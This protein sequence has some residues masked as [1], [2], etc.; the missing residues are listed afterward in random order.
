MWFPRDPVLLLCLGLSLGSVL[1]FQ[2]VYVPECSLTKSLKVWHGLHLYISPG[3][4]SENMK[5]QIMHLHSQE[6]F[7]YFQLLQSTVCTP[8]DYS[9]PS[10]L[11]MTTVYHLPRLSCPYFLSS[12]VSFL[13]TDRVPLIPNPLM[14]LIFLFVYFDAR[15]TRCQSK[16]IQPPLSNSDAGFSN[17]K[18]SR[19]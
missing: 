5:M 13:D 1:S 11:P 4:I 17:Y 16:I 2:C 8:S 12:L 14:S 3:T 7:K 10:I 15:I 19:N 9:L 6:S 18:Y